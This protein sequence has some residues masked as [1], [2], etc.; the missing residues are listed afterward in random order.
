MSE[1]PDMLAL[2]ELLN[3]TASMSAVIAGNT[4]G[5]DN[6]RDTDIPFH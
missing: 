5:R 3:N 4:P 2:K 1:R 6:L